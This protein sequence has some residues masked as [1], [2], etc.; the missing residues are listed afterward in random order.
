MPKDLQLF[1]S[2][3]DRILYSFGDN[4]STVE[5]LT[6]LIQEVLMELL[7]ETNSILS[8]GSGIPQIINESNGDEDITTRAAL[9]SAINLAKDHVILNQRSRPF[10]QRSQM[11]SD[12]IVNSIEFDGVEWLINLTISNV[13]GETAD[14][15]I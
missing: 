6:S 9:V 12:L 2:D 5:G 3:G 1:S 13:A 4:P 10:L 11:L 15:T 7:S 14:L 8:S